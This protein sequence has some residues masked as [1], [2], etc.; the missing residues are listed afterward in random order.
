MA[1]SDE[2]A[3]CL[4]SLQHAVSL[5]RCGHT[6]CRECI[7]AAAAA[8]RRQL[9]EERCPL[10]RRAISEGGRSA[11]SAFA[12]AR[13]G[14]TPSAYLSSMDNDETWAP[15]G[16]EQ[17]TRPLGTFGVAV[18]ALPIGVAFVVGACVADA[19]SSP[20]H[21]GDD[22]ASVIVAATTVYCRCCA[23]AA[24][25]IAV[26]TLATWEFL[27]ETVCGLYSISQ[28]ALCQ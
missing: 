13:R 7:A 21:G 20:P 25:G 17:I 4:G 24:E 9:V 5:S 6:F 27:S 2:C 19:T 8:N 28:D 22:V 18:G 14:A 12:A 1:D 26:L 3:I 16:P 15:W 10:C 23:D 11:L